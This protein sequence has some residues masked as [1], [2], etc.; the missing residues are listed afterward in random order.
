MHQPIDPA[1]YIEDLLVFGQYM[2]HVLDVITKWNFHNN[3]NEGIWPTTKS[4]FMEALR[5]AIVANFQN[6]PSKISVKLFLLIISMN[7]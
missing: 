4:K 5:S 3:S 7:P 1:Y 6:R 2:I